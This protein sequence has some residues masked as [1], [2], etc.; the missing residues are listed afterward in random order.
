ME[1]ATGSHKHFSRGTTSD[2][3][4]FF[5]LET[6]KTTFLPK[7]AIGKCQILN[8]SWGP[9][10]QTPPSDAHALCLQHFQ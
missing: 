1:F 5:P 9:C 2:E 3:I 8:S 4:S 7:I 10:P 6:K